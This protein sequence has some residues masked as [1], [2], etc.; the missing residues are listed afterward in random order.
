MP[1]TDALDTLCNATVPLVSSDYY[2]S[3]K[4]FDFSVAIILLDESPHSPF[5]IKVSSNFTV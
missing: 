1:V 2:G 4:S 5:R 3:I